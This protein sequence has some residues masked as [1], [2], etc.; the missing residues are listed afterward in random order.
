MRGLD[1]GGCE[2]DSKGNIDK[3]EGREEVRNRSNERM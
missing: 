1:K 2:E 3:R